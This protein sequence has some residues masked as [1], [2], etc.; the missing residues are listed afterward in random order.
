[1]THKRCI[2]IICGMVEELCQDK[3][4]PRHDTNEKVGVLL[5]AAV[6]LRRDLIAQEVGR[7]AMQGKKMHDLHHAMLKGVIN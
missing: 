6:K 7:Q 3:E 4:A 5:T 2:Q 1:M